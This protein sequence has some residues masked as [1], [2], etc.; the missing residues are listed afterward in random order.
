MEKVIQRL[1]RRVLHEKGA[2]PPV[3]VTAPFNPDLLFTAQARSHAVLQ[4]IHVSGGGRGLNHRLQS[5]AWTS[6]HRL[7]G[8]LSFCGVQASR[9]QESL[10]QHQPPG[11]GVPCRS[12][13]FPSPTSVHCEVPARA[14]AP[15]VS[16]LWLL[17]PLL[18]VLAPLPAPPAVSGVS[19]HRNP[20]SNCLICL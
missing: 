11:P 10:R 12:P 14:L 6:F 1:T 20:S 8:S 5:E 13:H 17:A 19:R 15:A 16:F 2:Q 3:T 9:R 18:T 4:G 7:K